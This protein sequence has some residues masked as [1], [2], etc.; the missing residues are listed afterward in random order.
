MPVGQ[1]PKLEH[2]QGQNHHQRQLE[3]KHIGNAGSIVV[4]VLPAQLSPAALMGL[5]CLFDLSDHGHHSLMLLQ[6]NLN[7]LKAS[8]W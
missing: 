3:Q 1:D 6:N 8:Q 7:L 2:K 5:C 4:A